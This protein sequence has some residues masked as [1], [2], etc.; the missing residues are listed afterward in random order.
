VGTTEDAITTEPQH[1]E[2]QKEETVQ[3]QVEQGEKQEQH[4]S[5]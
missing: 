5:E 4:V 1:N 3:A 2:E